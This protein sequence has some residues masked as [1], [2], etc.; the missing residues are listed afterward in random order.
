[1]NINSTAPN[2]KT[3]NNL[4]LTIQNNCG[5]TLKLDT[6]NLTFLSQDVARTPVDAPLK[7]SATNA[8]GKKYNLAFGQVNPQT[9]LVQSSSNSKFTLAPQEGIM[10]KGTGT[11]NGVAYD[12]K[13]ANAT[14]QLKDTAN[15]IADK[16]LKSHISIIGVDTKKKANASVYVENTCDTPQSL[17]NKEI[18]FLSQDLAG[19]PIAL[20]KLSTTWSDGVNYS[21]T[22][23]DNDGHYYVTTSLTPDAIVLPPHWGISAS[24]IIPLHGAKYDYFT[25]ERTMLVRDTTP[26]NLSACFSGHVF[27]DPD[28]TTATEIQVAVQNNCDTAQAV[29]DNIFSFVAQD[30]NKNPIWVSTLVANTTFPKALTYVMNFDALPDELN[31]MLRIITPIGSAPELVLQPH[32]TMTFEGT[33]PLMGQPFDLQTA[34]Q[35]FKVT[36]Q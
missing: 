28:A 24:G 13:T 14:L 34:E 1:M 30:V 10:L 22:F 7:F 17:K 8:D 29:K 6:Q 36:Q 9:G 12:W 2:S 35:S 31:Q 26:A 4:L 27:V 16:C 11:L 20:P 18:S 5:E 23:S 33:A 25:A 15:P 32:N 21:M 3:K 19:Y